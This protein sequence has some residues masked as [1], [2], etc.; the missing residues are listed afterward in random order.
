MRHALTT[1]QYLDYSPPFT[2]FKFIT[3]SKICLEEHLASD[4]GIN[5][6]VRNLT[7]KKI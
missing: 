1:Q 3:T 4:T 7:N 2:S 5:Y 6:Y